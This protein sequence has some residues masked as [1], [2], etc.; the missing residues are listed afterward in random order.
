[1]KVGEGLNAISWEIFKKVTDQKTLQ[2][3]LGYSKR[4]NEFIPDN[5]AFLD[6]YANLFYKLGQKEEAIA[7]EKEALHLA[8][9]KD[10]EGYKGMEETLRKMTA[11]EK[12]WKY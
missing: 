7:Q 2:V 3:A 10:I 12:T 6:T 4:V 8:D 5:A 9:K 1:M 11:G